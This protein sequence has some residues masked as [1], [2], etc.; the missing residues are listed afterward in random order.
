MNMRVSAALICTVS[1]VLSGCAVGGPASVSRSGTGLAPT[2]QV[3]LAPAPEGDRLA[4]AFA[5]ALTDELAKEGF[6]VGANGRFLV[7]YGVAVR[8]ASVGIIRADS[9]NNVITVSDVRKSLLL[10]K[11]AAQRLRITVTIL[12]MGEGSVAQRSTLDANGC[13]FPGEN[14]AG[15]AAEVA[16]LASRE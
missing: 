1:A 10:D 2:A 13:A 16:R 9:D 15:F 7:Q 4:S 8:Q 14:A 6:S 12:D 11:C 3:T 5:D